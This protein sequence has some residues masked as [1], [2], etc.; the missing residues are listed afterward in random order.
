MVWAW[1]NE[2]DKSKKTLIKEGILQ[3][4]YI[5]ERVIPMPFN[6]IFACAV[7]SDGNHNHNFFLTKD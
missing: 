3:K 2:Q 7:S 6:F 1:K 5:V 4:E